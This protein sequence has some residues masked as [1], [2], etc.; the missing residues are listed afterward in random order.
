MIKGLEDQNGIWMEGDDKL[1]EVETKYF[2]E[3]FSSK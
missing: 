1:L 3:L 2:R